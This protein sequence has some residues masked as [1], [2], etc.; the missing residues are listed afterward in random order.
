MGTHA[1]LGPLSIS[2]E[3]V[4]EQRKRSGIEVSK[5]YEER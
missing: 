5:T 1:A 2:Q 4:P 3:V